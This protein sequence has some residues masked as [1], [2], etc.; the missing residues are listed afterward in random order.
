MNLSLFDYH[1][2]NELIAQEPAAVRDAS[3]L[4]V[5]N[6]KTRS[7]T[8]A[9]FSEIGQYLPN[10][11]RFFRNNAAVLK[12]AYSGQRPL[13]ARSSAYYSNLLKMH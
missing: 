9:Q 8:H 1:L 4:M 12:H 13:A 11:P 3:R 6:R 7:V 2:P 10:R 5:V